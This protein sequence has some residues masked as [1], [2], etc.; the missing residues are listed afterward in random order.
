[1]SAAS[2]LAAAGAPNH[3]GVRRTVRVGIALGLARQRPEGGVLK[4][5][6]RVGVCH[7]AD[8][9]AVE[10]SSWDYGVALPI[11]SLISSRSIVVLAAPDFFRP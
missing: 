8:V 1:M 6:V 5:F 7:R 2:L 3:V 11:A 4:V 9:G 10:G